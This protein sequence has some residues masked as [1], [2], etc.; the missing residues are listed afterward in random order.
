MAAAFAVVALLFSG[1]A[2]AQSPPIPDPLPARLQIDGNNVDLSNGSYQMTSPGVA[3][4]QPAAGG[5]EFFMAYSED[6][7]RSNYVGSITISSGFYVVSM[8]LTSE[9]FSHSSGTFTSA[10]GSGATLTFDDPNNIYTYTTSDG[11][12]AKFRKTLTVGYTIV[13][14]NPPGSEAY[15]YEITSPNGVITTINNN[16]TIVDLDEG[17]PPDVPH[18]LG[19]YQ[20]IQSV[21]NNLGYRLHFEYLTDTGAQ[22]SGWHRIKKVT[23]LNNAVDQC[24]PQP[25]AC[26][27]LTEIWPSLEFTYHSS[28]KISSVKDALNRTTEYNY[29]GSDQLTGIEWPS[30]SSNNIT[31][32]YNGAGRVSSIDR[33][34]GTWNYVYSEGGSTRTTTVTNPENETTTVVSELASGLITSVSDGLSRTTTYAYDTSQRVT[35]LTRPEGDK[36]TYSYDSRGNV[37]EVRSIAKPGAGL[38]DMVTTATYPSSCSNQ[39]TCNKPTSTTDARG[40]V[41]NFTYNSTHGGVTSVKAPSVGG[42]RPETRNTYATRQ[43]RYKDANGNF[44]NGGQVYVMTETSSCATLSSC[45]G[46]ADETVTTINYPSSS[47]PNN[48]LPTSTTAGAG[49]GAVSV[50]S[51][52]TYDHNG[53]VLTIDGPLSGSADTARFYY[54]V[55]RQQTGVVGPDP[56]GGGALKFRAVKTVYNTDGLPTIVQTGTTTN[57]GA[58]AFSSFVSLRQ[59]QTIYDAYNRVKEARVYD[60]AIIKLASQVSYDSVGRVECQAQRMNPSLFGSLPTSA[61]SA[62]SSG[63]FGGDRIAKMVYDAAGQVLRAISAYGTA[64][65]QDTVTST[66]TLNGLV[67]TMTDANGNKTTYDYD[68][69][70]RL[71]KTSF[72]SKTTAGSSSSVD[73]TTASYHGS[74]ADKGLMSQTRTR[75]GSVYS[76][77]YDALGRVTT[78]TAPAGDFNTS[79]TY[80]NFSRIKTV[81]RNGQTL[82]YAYDQL[83]RLLSE[84]QAVGGAVSY[85]YDVAGRRTRMTWPDAF[86]VTYD[87][88][89]SG[90]VTHIR[91]NGATSGAGVL[92]SF[93][94]D[95][96]GRR[97]SVTRGN[98]F[99]TTYGFDALSRL[100]SLAQDLAGSADDQTYGF[101]YTPASQIASRTDTNADWGWVPTESGTDN[102]TVNG[103]NQYLTAAGSLPTYDDNGNLTAFNGATYTYDPSNRLKTANAGGGSATV[104]FTYDPG[105][106]LHK[107]AGTTGTRFLYDGSAMIAEYNDAGAVTE[108]YVHGPGTDEP[109]VWY[110]G[111]GTSNK[112]WL[113]SDARG[114]IAAVTNASG[115][116]T[117]LNTYDPYGKAASGNVGR[118]QYTG[119]MAVTDDGLDLYYY[120]ARFYEP[121]LKRFLQTDPIGYGDGMNM[122]AYVGGDPDLAG[123]ADDQTYGFSYTPASQIASR[124]DT[125]ADWGWLPT[126]SGTDNYTVNGLNQY[127]TAAGSLPTHDDN[128]NLTAFNGAT[129]TYDPLNRLKT[130]NAG[131]GSATVNFTYDPGGRLHKTAGTTGTRFLYDGSDMIAEYNDAGAVTERYV[132]GPGVDEPL[133]WYSGSGTSNKSW[134]GSDARGSIAA[135]T[136]MAVTDD[137]LDLYYYKARFYEPELKRFLQTDPIGYGDGMNMYAYVGGDPTTAGSSSSVD[138]TTASY[139]GSGADKGLMSQTRARNGSVYSYSYDALGRVTTMTAPAGDFNTSYTYDNFN[140]I[141]TVYFQLLEYIENMI[142][143]LDQ[144]QEHFEMQKG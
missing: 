82:S 109:L 34:F 106:R 131:G 48:L 14:S 60:G 136:N 16:V 135:V 6:A 77:S 100:T 23:A 3:V 1:L 125:N 78:M 138:Y 90:A 64:L 11:T 137:G 104:N 113:G 40:Q 89:V 49:N 116:M 25:G 71:I 139:H 7:W 87:Y 53:D 62:G 76:Y 28:G 74:G 108:R 111:S 75:G 58:S 73:Y 36:V 20:R 118:F 46:G 72:P 88:D 2:F 92:A 102:Y 132:H 99:T 94:Y 24:T 55:A 142:L 128:G 22:F 68:G 83:S 30:S 12:V 5:L 66:Y 45:N 19:Y 33:G 93:A 91:E 35:S 129:Y 123:S 4:G 59:Q 9:A 15:L 44:V 39:V 47:T 107:T 37:T 84:T 117:A 97:S 42:V 105:G 95:D 119:Q 63:A 27:G 67:K 8:G 141:K 10:R 85:Q 81:S 61:C 29:N 115:A 86:Y 41:T 126:E 120:K 98:G 124:T 121:E 96:L 143:T 79:Y 80:D 50:T 122:Y 57:N 140:R 69:F 114:S 101:S 31:I 112:S 103:L 38:S 133:V 32:G 127:L 17:L 54:D 18:R 51:T 52:F 130:A 110:A 26:V 13:E 134:L 56:D 70:D 65:Q 43:A 144:H 21:A